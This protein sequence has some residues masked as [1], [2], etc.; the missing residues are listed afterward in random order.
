MGAAILALGLA[1]RRLSAALNHAVTILVLVFSEMMHSLVTTREGQVAGMPAYDLQT[2]W[3]K[4]IAEV[5]LEQGRAQLAEMSDD[6]ADMHPA[7]D[8][9]HGAGGGRRRL[10]F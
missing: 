3:A 5:H 2:I 6:R 9:A 10:H 4:E 7:P 8:D 1:V